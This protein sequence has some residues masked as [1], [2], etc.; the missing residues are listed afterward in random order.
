M[1]RFRNIPRVYMWLATLFVIL[2]AGGVWVWM[3]FFQTYH[4][5]TVQEGVLYRDG[6][7]TLREFQTAVTDVQ[8]KA[9]VCFLDPNE[10]S[11]EPFDVEDDFCRRSKIKFVTIGIPL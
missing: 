1:L 3:S 5:A 10:R 9:I 6:F 11:R 7:R 8:P 4:L 2:V